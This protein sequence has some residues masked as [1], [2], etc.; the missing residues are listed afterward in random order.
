MPYP[1]AEAMRDIYRI[2]RRPKPVTD[3]A[4]KFI[5]DVLAPGL[6]LAVHWRFEAEG[7]EFGGKVQS[8]CK[9][10]NVSINRII[11]SWPPRQREGLKYTLDFSS[12]SF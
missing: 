1:D 11:F 9:S 3:I 2:L 12:L 10:N 7:G 5:K 4:G 6:F 8:L